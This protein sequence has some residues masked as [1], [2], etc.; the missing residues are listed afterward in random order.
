MYILLN[1]SQDNSMGPQV[2]TKMTHEFDPR[3][4]PTS[5]T[6]DNDPRV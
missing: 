3:E 6:H 5:L 2:L 1:I 4:W